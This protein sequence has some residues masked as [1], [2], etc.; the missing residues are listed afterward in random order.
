M[1]SISIIWNRVH[2]F[3]FSLIATDLAWINYVTKIMCTS[4]QSETYSYLCLVCLVVKING[5]KF[6]FHVADIELHASQCN[7]NFIT[8]I[9]GRF[10]RSEIHTTMAI[11]NIS[12]CINSCFV[13][14]VH[15]D[16]FAA[17]AFFT[18]RCQIR[19]N[20]EIKRNML[21]MNIK[22]ECVSCDLGIPFHSGHKVIGNEELIGWVN[23]YRLIRLENSF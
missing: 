16:C 11:R 18:R 4:L 14:R 17:F 8:Y 23:K 9:I 15:W 3:K 6:Y 1:H 5:C 2:L 7:A 10:R 12:R 19:W 21:N 20:K 22:F 13:S